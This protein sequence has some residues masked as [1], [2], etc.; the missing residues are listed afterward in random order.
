M[1]PARREG[2]EAVVLTGRQRAAVLCTVLGPDF[3]S[4]VAQHL[5]PEEMDII[6]VETARL[7]EVSTPVADLVLREWHEII[8]AADFLVEGGAEYAREI[9]ERTFGPDGATEMLQRIERQLVDVAGLHRLRKADPQQLGG[10]LRYEHPQTIA[11][12]LAHLAP[13]HTAVVLKELEPSV[14]AEVVYR[15]ARME[16]V[17]PDMLQ[18]IERALGSEMEMHVSQRM[19]VSGGPK[20]VA[21]VMHLVPPALEKE[22]LGGIGLRDGELREQIENLMFLFEDLIR[23]DDRALQRLLREVEPREL[24]LALKT[25]S[26]PLRARLKEQMTTRAAMALEDEMEWLGPVRVRD[27]ESAQA[28]IVAVV[29]ALENVGELVIGI[30][31]HDRIVA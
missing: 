3:T 30:G 29:R 12:I 13:A 27:V 10:M 9:L 20:A 28:R 31:A 19:S 26:E 7:E 18:L 25:A 2:P 1:L 4:R 24:A 17:S 5:T 21:A 15:M 23:L 8:R 22:L 11:L 6:S 14:A 16:S